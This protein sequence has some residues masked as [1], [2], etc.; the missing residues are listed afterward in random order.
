MNSQLS[1]H[2]LIFYHCTHYTPKLACLKS[3]PIINSFNYEYTGSTSQNS[4]QE[5]VIK[6][7]LDN[8]RTPIFTTEGFFRYCHLHS[9]LK[10]NVVH[11]NYQSK[12]TLRVAYLFQKKS[13]RHKKGR[14]QSK[15]GNVRKEKKRK[16]QNPISEKG[17][18]FEK[19]AK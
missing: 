10:K 7:N 1:F 2:L 17:F 15:E 6:F 13:E 19:N 11:Y 9:K 8:Q 5:S 16:N 14:S 4:S 18:N 12:N 3:R